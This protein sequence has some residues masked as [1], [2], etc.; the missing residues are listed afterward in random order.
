MI[1][2][3]MAYFQACT[4]GGLGFMRNVGRGREGRGGPHFWEVDLAHKAVERKANFSRGRVDHQRKESPLIGPGCWEGNGQKG[5]LRVHENR[6][7]L[8]DTNLLSVNGESNRMMSVG[9]G[10]TV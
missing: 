7:T 1:L 3:S 6:K 8:A 2:K 9:D 10:D 4:K 5:R